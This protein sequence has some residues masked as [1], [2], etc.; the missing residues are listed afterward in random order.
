MGLNGNEIAEEMR[1]LQQQRNPAAIATFDHY[2]P[3]DASRVPPKALAWAAAIIFI[4][5]L[6]GYGLF[7]T[8]MAE[9]DAPAPV[10]AV[11]TAAPATRDAALAPD[12]AIAP[13]A[14]LAVTAN[15][16][17]WFGLNDAAGRLV[18]ERTLNPGESYVLSAEQ[19][20]LTLRTGRPQALRLALGGREL[21]QLGADDILVKDVALDAAGLARRLSATPAAAGQ[22]AAANTTR[23][24]DGRTIRLRVIRCTNADC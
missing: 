1:S 12:A 24:Y 16:R 20:Q 3:A 22:S 19:R 9:P 21:P 7:R 11:E 10:S 14:A 13:D 6:A 5:M 8:M 23:L 18:I 15:G 2:E 4:L 17:A